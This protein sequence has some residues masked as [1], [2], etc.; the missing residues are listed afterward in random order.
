[1]G[2][3]PGP[4]LTAEDREDIPR[5][6]RDKDQLIVYLDS[7]L[8]Q[9]RKQRCRRDRDGDRDRADASDLVDSRLGGVAEL[10]GSHELPPAGTRSAFM[11]TS[12]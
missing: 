11:V 8:G 2:R 10:L 5:H 1:M 9:R 3:G 4:L 6:G 12:S 7:E